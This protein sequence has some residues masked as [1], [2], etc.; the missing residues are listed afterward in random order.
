MRLVRGTWIVLLLLA[1]VALTYGD[2][3]DPPR[4][5]PGQGQI[6]YDVMQLPWRTYSHGISENG[7][8]GVSMMGF[9]FDW[10]GIQGDRF[11]YPPIAKYS[12]AILQLR[13]GGFET[14]YRTPPGITMLSGG[15]GRGNY[16]G[17]RSISTQ[18]PFAIESDVPVLIS[19]DGIRDLPLFHPDFRPQVLS[20]V[21]MVGVVPPL[22]DFFRPITGVTTGRV[23]SST[24][25]G[26][27]PIELRINGQSV[28]GQAISIADNGDAI[29]TLEPESSPYMRRSLIWRANGS[30]EL[31]SQI[32]MAAINSAGTTAVGSMWATIQFVGS[33]EISGVMSMA[34]RYSTAG[35]QNIVGLRFNSSAWSVNNA[36]WIIG[37]QNGASVLIRDGQIINLESSIDRQLGLS[38]LHAW[39]ITNQGLIEGS[40]FDGLGRFVQIVLIPRGP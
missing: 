6:L 36:G 10:E 19:P 34:V 29:V 35:L 32:E 28:N 26:K 12:A 39:R 7:L 5:D 25:D 20:P 1:A 22:G 31:F 11:V 13:E 23:F 37:E 30:V 21:R 38:N 15:D 40:A 27:R 4:S 2:K 33:N 18:T 17:T 16:L 3:P 24:L 8:L 9:G 14:V